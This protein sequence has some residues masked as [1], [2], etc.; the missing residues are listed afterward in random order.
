M[1]SYMITT[2]KGSLMSVEVLLVLVFESKILR[3]SKRLASLNLTP[4]AIKRLQRK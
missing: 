2:M 3:N 1:V 4:E